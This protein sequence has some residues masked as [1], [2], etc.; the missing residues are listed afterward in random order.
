MEHDFNIWLDFLK[1]LIQKITGH[2]YGCCQG[3]RNCRRCLSRNDMNG[4]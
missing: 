3:F 2:R 4:G 1:P